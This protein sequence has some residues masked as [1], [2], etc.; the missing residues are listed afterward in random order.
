[1]RRTSTKVP[2]DIVP[3]RM[4]LAPRYMMSALTTPKSTVAERLI[5]EVAVSVFKTFS[6]RRC[7][8]PAK[9]S[10]SRSSAW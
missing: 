3:A 7:T 10:S 2:S 8:P 6:S 9:T 5:T 1:M 4:R